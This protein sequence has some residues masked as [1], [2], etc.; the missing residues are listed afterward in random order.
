MLV[1][2]LLTVGELCMSTRT[3]GHVQGKRL[4]AQAGGYGRH[5]WK[6]LTHVVPITG[7]IAAQLKAF[8]LPGLQRLKNAET[9]G[10]PI[11]IYSTSYRLRMPLFCVE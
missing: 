2:G 11:T 9:V 4:D 8:L 1:C 7:K 6:E 10:H 3:S 5:Q